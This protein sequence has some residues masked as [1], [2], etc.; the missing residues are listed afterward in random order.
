MRMKMMVRL[1]HGATVIDPETGLHEQIIVM[2][3]TSLYPSIMRAYNISPT[4]IIK[5]EQCDEYIE[6]VNV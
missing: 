6:T 3:F 4:M 5:D 1:V 2:D